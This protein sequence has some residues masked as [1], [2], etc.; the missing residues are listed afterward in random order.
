MAEDNNIKM[1]RERTVWENI[2]V[3]DTLDKGFIS[4]T[5]EEL[6]QLYSGRQTAQ[7]RAKDLNRHF[8]KEDIQRALRYERMLS[9]TSHQK[10]AN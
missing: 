8:S 2:F 1:K 4:K 6:T 10:N 9:I 7:C 5:Y 3:N